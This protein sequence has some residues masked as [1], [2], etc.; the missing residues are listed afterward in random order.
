MSDDI[1]EPDA[2][3]FEESDETRDLDGQQVAGTYIEARGGQDPEA[4]R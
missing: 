1:E 4:S 3:A 2:D